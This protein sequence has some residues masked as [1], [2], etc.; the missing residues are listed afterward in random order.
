VTRYDTPLKPYLSSP[1]FTC[2]PQDSL[3]RV[4]RRLAEVGISSLAVVDGDD[5]LVGVISRTDLL[6]VGRREADRDVGAT[7]LALPDRTVADEMTR[8]PVTVDLDA[9]VAE[10]AAAMNRRDLHRLFVVRDGI[11]VGVLSTRDVMKAI[12]DRRDPRRIADHMSKPLL[13]VAATDPISLATE[14]LARARVTGLVV[15][16]DDWP[17]GVF[18]QREAL[19]SRDLAAEVAVDDVMNTAFICLSA[20]TPLRRAAEQAVA[21]RV[22]RVIVVERRAPVGILTGLDFAR[23]THD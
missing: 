6:R 17:V 22:R 12:R 18:T 15:L 3:V 20:P 11:L 5:H 7:L 8:E 21:M 13:T 14:R 2:R 9:T 10:A 23:A 1:V 4:E 16:E 19:A